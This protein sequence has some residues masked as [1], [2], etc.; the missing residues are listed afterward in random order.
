M[1]NYCRTK[2]C[3]R[4]C[5]IAKIIDIRKLNAFSLKLLVNIENVYLQSKKTENMRTLWFVL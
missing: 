4:Q 1:A 5:E 3:H 2:I